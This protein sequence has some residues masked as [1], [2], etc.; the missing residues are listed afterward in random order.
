LRFTSRWGGDWTAMTFFNTA[1]GDEQIALVKGKVDPDKP[2][3]VRMHTLSSLPTCSA[4]CP[5]AP[6]CCRARWR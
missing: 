5:L 3:L 6:G 2:T 1:T 4:R